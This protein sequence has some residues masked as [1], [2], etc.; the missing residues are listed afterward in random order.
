[1][2]CYHPIPAYRT[3]D[4]AVKLGPP[5]GRENL[6][7]PC[8]KC[9]GCR[10]ARAS[11]WAH[12][13]THEAA[14]WD[15][16]TFL[17]L[18][19]DDDHLPQAGHLVPRD[20]QLFIK[21]LRKHAYGDGCGIDRSSCGPIRYFA[22][23]EYG[24]QTGRP[25]YHV[26]LFNC[27]FTDRYKVGEDLYAS[28]VLRRL[29]PSGDNRFCAATPATASYIAQYN[30]KKIG[31]WDCDSDGVVYDRPP[32]FLRMSLRPAI[33]AGWLDKYSEDLSQGYLVEGGSRKPIP[34]Y[35]LEKLKVNKPELYEAIVGRKSAHLLSVPV[36][37]NSPAR[38]AA[39][40]VI[41]KRRK[42]LIESRGM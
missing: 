26:L 27:G 25:H 7:L 36:E 6:A 1:M 5:L 22:C 31:A 17:T 39:A 11:M 12:R 18:T 21:R 28:D 35:Y 4:G 19:Y 8:G 24:E 16:N 23:G 41:H 37:A 38:L 33:G 3:E 34:R 30:L 29:W 14:L 40:E 13:C 2:A 32:P 10:T 20:L 15:S 9:L 42:E